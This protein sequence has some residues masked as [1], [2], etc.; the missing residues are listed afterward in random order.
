MYAVTF[1]DVMLIELVR[2]ILVKELMKSQT[3]DVNEFCRKYSVGRSVINS[4]IERLKQ[5]LSFEGNTI[6]LLDKIGF[7]M[8][9]INSGIPAYD[10]VKL[11]D[12]KEYEELCSR[13][14][15]THG[16]KVH[17]NLHFTSHGKRFEIDIVAIQYPYV[18]VVDCKHWLRL[19]GRRSALLES[20]L[21]HKERF[22][23]FL[24]VAHRLLKIPIEV[25]SKLKF[26]PVVITFY[27][28]DQLIVDGIV[29]IPLEKLGRLLV[30]LEDLPIEYSTI[31]DFYTTIDNKSKN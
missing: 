28:Q 30:D 12:W 23:E 3:L 15:S 9:S 22:K 6:V 24:E 18:L 10:I 25:T 17:R 5:Y 27:I 16:F 19:R 20:T 11:M 8:E 31:K 13:I 14:L 7:A 21:R 4:A 1:K 26:I 29:T 2:T